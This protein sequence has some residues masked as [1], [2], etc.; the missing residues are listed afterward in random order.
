MSTKEGDDGTRSTAGA[1]VGVAAG[2][3]A[4]A[5]RGLT[6]HY[7]PVVALDGV[8]LDVGP[9]SIHALIGANGSGKSTLIR[10]VAG[11]E[12][13]AP[14]GTV[15]VGAE[16]VAADRTSPA[17]SHAAGLR[18]VHQGASTFPD[19]TVAENIGLGAGLPTR[20]GRSIRWSQARSTASDA[21][22][23]LG[24]AVD[25]ASRLGDLGPAVQTLVAI[26][27]AL[28]DVDASGE[29]EP[30]LVVL[31]EPTAALP[32]REV[33]ALRG[34]LRHLVAAGH[35]VLLVAHRLDEVTRAAD[36]ATVL[37]DARRVAS[38]AVGSRPP[39][40][41]VALITGSAAGTRSTRPQRSDERSVERSSAF[42]LVAAE[43]SSERRAAAEAPSTAVRSA[44]DGPGGA[45]GDAGRSA[46]VPS[47]AGSSA[48][49]DRAGPAHPHDDAFGSSSPAPLLAVRGLRAGRLSGVSFSVGDGEIVGV[50]G[51][52]GSGR[53]TLL[54]ALFGVRRASADQV[55]L[56]GDVLALNA[57]GRAMAAGVALVPEQRERS[58]FATSPVAENLSIADLDRFRQGGRAGRV[59]RHAERAAAAGDLDRYSVVAGS[60]DAPMTTL[61]GG[62]QQKVVLARWLRRDPRLLLLDEPTLGVDVGARAELHR[63]IRETA[64]AGGRAVLCVSSD[65]EE[66]CA[67]AD[68]I[69]VL[70]DGRLVDEVS[71]DDARPDRVNQLVHRGAAA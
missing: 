18:V 14:G 5:V 32:E 46:P 69:L 49:D 13:G 29:A 55:I 70:H 33:A 16:Q 36:H 66:L 62:N 63:L 38:F 41:V 28:A 43:V 25:P 40:E 10:V 54:E 30:R 6:R 22:A 31:D 1:G 42:P 52:L 23:R 2:R 44:T 68:R 15:S 3:P 20:P 24:V 27:R 57:P 53:S 60:A 48:A 19:L 8:D 37:R 67:L 58:V 65:V 12:R 51:L 34:G 50:A 56:A 47:A 11:V 35:A 7:G 64:A 17:W 45:P 9:G 4:L 26:A 21:L 61:S 71:G 59:D 39:D